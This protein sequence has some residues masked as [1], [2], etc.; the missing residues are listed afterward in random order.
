MEIY[1]T[2]RIKAEVD[3]QY[4]EHCKSLKPDETPKNRM[5]IMHAVTKR[6]YNEE[7]DEVKQKVEDY[8]RQ[9]YDG[10]LYD[11]DPKARNNAYNEQVPLISV[12]ISR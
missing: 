8:R 1:Y 3:N 5:T 2:E 9:R 6:M 7:P 4:E 10:T 11:N 12:H